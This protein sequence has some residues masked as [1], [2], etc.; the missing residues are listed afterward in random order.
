MYNL[1]QNNVKRAVYDDCFNGTTILHPN[2]NIYSANL[3]LDDSWFE[4]SDECSY[5][6]LATMTNGY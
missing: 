1:V 3:I 5:K 2:E 4:S 6:F